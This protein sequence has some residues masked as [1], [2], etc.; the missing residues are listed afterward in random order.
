MISIEAYRIRIGT[1][2]SCSK[3]S[4]CTSSSPSSNTSSISTSKTRLVVMFIS[5][6]FCF[7]LL[8]LAVHKTAILHSRIRLL[9][10]PP[11]PACDPSACPC[12]TMS[13]PVPKIPSLQKYFLWLP[14]WPPPSQPHSSATTSFTPQPS[15]QSS[16]NC[17]YTES[18]L[19][20][21][22]IPNYTAKHVNFLARM[23]HGNRKT[24][25]IKIQHW[26]KGPSH[27]VNKHYQIEALIGEHR[28]HVLG[29][30][31]ANVYSTHDQADIQHDG[32]DL[33]VA[34][35]IN[36]PELNVA[37]VVVYTHQSLKVKRRPDLEN[38]SVS[39]VWL[40]VGLPRQKKILMCHAYR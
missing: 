20:H 3:V 6:S 26:N 25:G 23:V 14:P 31:E 4:R 8:T 18:S 38:D 30:S 29:L 24:R 40:E 27:L 13:G 17:T 33:H 7:S 35:T 12:P 34:S 36:N 5:F 15:I 1:F 16:T 19:H 32:Y 10:P 21:R 22:P 37:R 9:Q 11:S 39:S 28:P 2:G